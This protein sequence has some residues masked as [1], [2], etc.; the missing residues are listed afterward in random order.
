MVVGRWGGAM[1]RGME[2]GMYVVFMAFESCRE[3]KHL[4]IGHIRLSSW[5]D[6]S[7]RG[8]TPRLT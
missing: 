2:R 4:R 8:D 3:L 6:G 7:R 5:E 1:R